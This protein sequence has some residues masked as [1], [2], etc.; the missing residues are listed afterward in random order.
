MESQFEIKWT[1]FEDKFE[2]GKQQKA[3]EA[4]A[5]H[6]FCLEFG[7]K[8]GLFRY[9]NQAGIETDPAEVGDEIIG[10]Q[11]KYYEASISLS[12]K[13]ADLMDAIEK[14]K[15]KNPSLTKILFY[16][17]KEFAESTKKEKKEPDYKIEIEQ[18]GKDKGVVIEW[19][20]KSHFEIQLAKPEN[21]YVAEYYFGGDRPVWKFIEN[22]EEHTENLLDNINT[23]IFYEEERIHF[24]Q[25]I[26]EREYEKWIS[27][28]IPC[29]IISGDG[30]IG[31]T[32]FVKHWKEKNS[33]IL[34]AWRLSEFNVNS[35][36]DVFAN[37]GNFTVYDFVETLSE[38][39]YIRWRIYIQRKRIPERIMQ[40]P[41]SERYFN[42]G[43]PGVYGLFYG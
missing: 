8:K 31:K 32:A 17:N 24:Q 6:L 19:R 20:V 38:I 5:Y 35:L 33:P 26:C 28:N 2:G 11:A 43:N 23:E 3:F 22:I 41:L 15:R 37:Y 40:S 7:L 14:A 13:K 36:Q 16:T 21:K 4:L 1:N 9:K 34:F 25:K 12:S 18:A 39:R 29:V 42:S 10:F 27:D 30:G